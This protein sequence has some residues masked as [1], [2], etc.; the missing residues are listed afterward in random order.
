MVFKNNHLGPIFI[1][2]HSTTTLSPIVRG[3][4]GVEI[5][6]EMLTRRMGSVGLISTMPRAGRHGVDLFR[7]PATMDEALEMFKSHGDYKKIQYFEKKYSFYSQDQEEYLEKINTH[8]QFW[9]TAETLAPK[10]PLFVIIHGQAS[11][12]KNFP[13]ILEVSTNSGKWIEEDLIK[14][15]IEKANSKNAGRIKQLKPKLKSYVLAWADLWLRRSLG[16]RFREFK[17][18]NLEGSYQ[19]DMRK[20]IEKAAAILGMDAKRVEKGMD[21]EKYMELLK[22]CIDATEFRITYQNIFTGKRGEA[23]VRHLLA[24]TGGNAMMFETSA[25]LN[26][27]YPKTSLIMVEDIINYISSKRRWRIFEK[28]IGEEK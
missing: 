1:A 27:M 6:T 24:K 21:W 17:M 23:N 10:N 9:V 16:Y 19:R 11:R 7:K 4:V 14:E 8:N 26:E 13:S 20:D 2:P 22:Q 5:I 3:D 25:F 28:Y 12:L 15:A 18:K